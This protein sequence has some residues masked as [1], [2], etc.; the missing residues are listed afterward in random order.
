MTA[1]STNAPAEIRPTFI[2]VALLTD[3]FFFFLLLAPGF[4]FLRRGD[5]YSAS[6]ELDGLRFR[7][8]GGGVSKE[9][10]P[11]LKLKST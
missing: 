10:N 5:W 4:F 3:C 2:S 9:I 8:R 1:T 11:Y 6:G 7:R